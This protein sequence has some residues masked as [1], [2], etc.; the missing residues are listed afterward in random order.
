MAPLIEEVSGDG[1]GL[2]V[3]DRP[4]KRNAMSLELLRG[5]CDVLER[6]GRDERVRVVVFSGR[7]PAFSA[8][9][10]RSQLFDPAVLPDIVDASKRYH[11]ALW[12]FPKPTVAAVNGPA[13]GGG[14]DLAALCDVRIASTEAVFAHPEIKF[15][16][17]PLYTPLRWIVGNGLARDLCLTGRRVGADEALRIGLVSRVVAA[18]ALREEAEAL[19]LQI[20]EAPQETL[21]ITKGYMTAANDDFEASFVREHDEVFERVLAQLSAGG[22]PGPPP[23]AGT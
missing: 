7:P 6:W 5:L 15:G 8:G 11:R 4:E 14:F 21:E 18:R 22:A 16:A 13:F 10:D 9:F 20:A 19:A 12:A 3:L 2:V 1:L 17:P 23:P